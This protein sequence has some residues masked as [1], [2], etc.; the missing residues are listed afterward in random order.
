MPTTN[1]S[2]GL[3]HRLLGAPGARQRDALCGAALANI[4]PLVGMA[5]FILGKTREQIRAAAGEPDIVEQLAYLEGEESWFYLEHNISLSF[6]AATRW[7]L[8]SVTYRSE[9]YGIGGLQFVGLHEKSLISQ[10]LRAGLE[11]LAFESDHDEFGRC[12]SSSLHALTFWVVDGI[13]QNF[14]IASA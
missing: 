11:D 14:I 10:G 4:K 1:D 13:V 6:S 9:K 3:P 12:F 5:P 7:R 2:A 8:A